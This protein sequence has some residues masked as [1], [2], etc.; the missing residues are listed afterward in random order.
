MAI[1]MA[2]ILTVTAVLD[3]LW[4]DYAKKFADEKWHKTLK[5][6]AV[7]ILVC[8]G[9]FLAIIQ[10]CKDRQSDTDM[11]GLNTAMTKT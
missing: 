10:W 9:W 2:L 11:E 7:I 1:L 3:Y 5:V 6:T 4:E 8:F